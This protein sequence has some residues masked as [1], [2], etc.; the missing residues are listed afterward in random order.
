MPTARETFKRPD[1]HINMSRTRKVSDTLCE[2]QMLYI[3]AGDGA[4]LLLPAG[5]YERLGKPRTIRVDVW[6]KKSSTPRRH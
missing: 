3:E 1:A 4:S 5:T 6:N 2:Y